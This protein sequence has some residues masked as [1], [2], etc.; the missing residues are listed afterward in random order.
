[1]A[2]AKFFKSCW[3]WGRRRGMTRDESWGQGLTAVDWRGGGQI[4]E[5][6]VLDLP[7]HCALKGSVLSPG[8]ACPENI[9]LDPAQWGSLWGR[10]SRARARVKPPW[11]TLDV[12]GHKRLSKK[13]EGGESEQRKASRVSKYIKKGKRRHI[14]VTISTVP[15]I[16]GEGPKVAAGWAAIQAEPE[17]Q[18]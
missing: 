11:A 4:L 8:P 1:M 7:L 2:A 16:L 5:W 13:L 12:T 9:L 3:D 17:E 15:L 14:P 18:G 6:R 10:P